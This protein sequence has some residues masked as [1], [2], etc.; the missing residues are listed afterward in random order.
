MKAIFSGSAFPR[1]KVDPA[2]DLRPLLFSLGLEIPDGHF[3]YCLIQQLSKGY[4]ANSHGI[5]ND[6]KKRKYP[7]VALLGTTIVLLLLLAFSS[8]IVQTA[9]AI[10]NTQIRF[11]YQDCGLSSAGCGVG[12][13]ICA[14]GTTT[15]PGPITPAF[16]VVVNKSPGSPMNGNWSAVI[17]GAAGLFGDF[18][19]IK[20]LSF[21]GTNFTAKGNW[22]GIEGEGNVVNHSVAICSG[23]PIDNAK[24]TFF[25]QCG[26]TELKFEAANGV[27]ATI[28]GQI[29][30]TAI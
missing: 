11:V 8:A 5:G 1:R 4:M 10:T 22:Q 15:G 20:T 28:Q 13:I 14:D 16:S 12:T 19:Q 30:C 27:R 2:F 25:G 18:G 21:D 29:T 9:S 6:G 17:P 24:V 23:E 26:G 7:S 3:L